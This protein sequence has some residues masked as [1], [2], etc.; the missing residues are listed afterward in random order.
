VLLLSLS[1][2]GQNKMEKEIHLLNFT[3]W[4]LFNQ[5][6]SMID[7]K[8]FKISQILIEDPSILRIFNP[9]PLAL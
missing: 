3:I 1:K 9:C 2:W 7:L 5:G 8:G 4:N 6:Y